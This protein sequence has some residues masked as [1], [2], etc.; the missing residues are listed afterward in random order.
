ME[1][2]GL[3]SVCLWVWHSCHAFYF[4]VS[5]MISDSFKSKVSN[6]AKILV[7]LGEV[8]NHSKGLHHVAVYLGAKKYTDLLTLDVTEEMRLKL[9]KL[10]DELIALK[11][12]L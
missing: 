11:K 4:K 2:P 10:S 3:S 6:A 1:V 5:T 8:P 12:A 9:R 7:K